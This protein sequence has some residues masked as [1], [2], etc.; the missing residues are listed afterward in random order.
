MLLQE[1]AYYN[2][3]PECQRKDIKEE[4]VPIDLTM[5]MIMLPTTNGC[6]RQFKSIN[7]YSTNGKPIKGKNNTN[8]EILKI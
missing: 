5:I 7:R 4:L 3:L 2:R 8:H 6:V 1:D